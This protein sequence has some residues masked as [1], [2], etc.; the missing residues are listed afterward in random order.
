MRLLDRYLLHLRQAT[1][2]YFKG[3]RGYLCLGYSSLLTVGALVRF[4]GR[5]I[6]IGMQVCDSRA[7]AEVV[8]IGAT[9]KLM[10]Y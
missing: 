8:T 6:A 5:R 2:R 1:S 3:R 10:H 9:T 7:G 4:E